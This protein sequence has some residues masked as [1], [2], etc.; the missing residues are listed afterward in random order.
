MPA[1]L[2]PI[3]LLAALLACAGRS[4]AADGEAVCFVPARNAYCPLAQQAAVGSGCTCWDAREATAQIALRDPATGQVRVP[5]PRAD[6]PDTRAVPRGLA[7]GSALMSQRFEAAAAAREPPKPLLSP[8]FPV[9]ATLGTCPSARGAAPDLPAG[10]HEQLLRDGVEQPHRRRVRLLGPSRPPG[11]GRRRG[12]CG[13]CR[14]A[15]GGRDLAEA[16]RP[17]FP[18]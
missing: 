11:P 10:R 3:A 13:G 17:G 16:A 2:R 8:G 7:A 14:R 5:D 9:A 4:I 12:R 1:L 18:K 15:E 6:P